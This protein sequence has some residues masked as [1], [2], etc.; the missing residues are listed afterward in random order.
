MVDIIGWV[1]LVALVILNVGMIALSI[2][3][4]MASSR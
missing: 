3:L 2:A 4:R 1:I